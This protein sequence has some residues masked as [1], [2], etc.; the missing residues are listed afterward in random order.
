VSAVSR[1]RSRAVI[2][3]MGKLNPRPIIFLSRPTANSECTAEEAYKHT[4]CRALFASGSPFNPVRMNGKLM[5]PSQANNAYV[6]PGVA[7]GVVAGRVTRVTDEMFMAAAHTLAGMVSKEDLA[8]GLLFPPAASA[9]YRSDRNRGGQGG[10]RADCRHTGSARRSAG[11]RR[12]F[13]PEYRSYV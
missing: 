4:E 7:L 3:L 11:S 8:S 1:E 9:R 10:V 5:V 2:E 12:V 13:E 6:F